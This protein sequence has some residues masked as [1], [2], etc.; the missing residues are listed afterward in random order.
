MKKQENKL[1]HKWWF[2]LIIGAVIIYALTIF[3]LKNENIS[4]E[5]DTMEQMDKSWHH[6]E[7]IIGGSE[8]GSYP[9][10]IQGEKFKLTY[11]VAQNENY[12]SLLT[13]FILDS[14]SVEEWNNRLSENRM[15]VKKVNSDKSVTIIFPVM[16]E[17]GV[18]P[19]NLSA[20][21]HETYSGGV[22]MITD[23]IQDLWY[24]EIEQKF[25]NTGE[26]DLR[27]IYLED[28]QSL[29]ERKKSRNDYIEFFYSY[30]SPSESSI[31]QNGAGEYYL[32]VDSYGANDWE[33]VIEDYY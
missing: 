17:M 19:I 2:W 3:A 24:W 11:S 10:K 26:I 16:E 15:G 30:N 33:I 5:R 13:M 18:S 1:H 28:V 22:G 32:M 20:E 12:L 27:Y 14:D 4:Q 8:G 23:N 7:K 31:S 6:V 25:E 29:G 9:F 21:E